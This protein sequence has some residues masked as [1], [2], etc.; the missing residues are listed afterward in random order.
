[1]IRALVIRG[2]RNI[3]TLRIEGEYKTLECRIKGKVLKG[4]E[5]F[6]NPLAPGDWVLVEEDPAH[7]GT[8]RIIALE[9]R[10]NRFTRLN[11]KGRGTNRSASSQLLAANVEWI[12]CVTTPVSPPWRP[13][14]LDRALVQADIAGIQA[15]ILCNKWD[16]FD[17][18]PDTD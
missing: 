2:S 16:L 12:L 6:Y 18:D 13:R 14:F 1:M 11:Q 10:R 5:T 4:V 15:A 8:G 17:G 9:E 7:P 3:F